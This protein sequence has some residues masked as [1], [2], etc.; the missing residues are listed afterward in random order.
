MGEA[1]AEEKEN[2]LFWCR[3]VVGAGQ[4]DGVGEMNQLPPQ[5]KTAGGRC[6][7]DRSVRCPASALN[8]E[9]GGR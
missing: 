2:C 6:R 3:H 5:E 4:V 7:F 8:R 1:E 9:Y